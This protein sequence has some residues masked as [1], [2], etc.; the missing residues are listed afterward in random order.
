MT[1]K[2]R[3]R[4]PRSLPGMKSL[5]VRDETSP[6]STSNTSTQRK[7]QSIGSYFDFQQVK[8]PRPTSVKEVWPTYADF[9]DSTLPVKPQQRVPEGD[10]GP[11]PSY[12]ISGASQSNTKQA[13]N[14]TV[15]DKGPL[16]RGMS[17][18]QNFGR[19]MESDIRSAITPALLQMRA[20]RS[21]SPLEESSSDQSVLLE[22]YSEAS[23]T[24]GSVHD[25]ETNMSNEGESSDI[26]SN[27]SMW[28]A[29]GNHLYPDDVQQMKMSERR[30][31][32][33]ENGSDW[34]DDGEFSADSERIDENDGN[35]DE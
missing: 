35:E 33:Q 19:Y 5:S 21:S 16:R 17:D 12:R 6:P 26:D 3:R 31:Y 20:L 2:H 11:V 27:A 7:R 32:E 9:V 29:D 15:R 18:F 8:R 10:K 23:S 1:G 22:E 30:A 14:T 28:D 25:E 13:A 24:P 34:D 4:F